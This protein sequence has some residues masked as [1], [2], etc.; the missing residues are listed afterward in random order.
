[1]TDRTRLAAA[2]WADRT[3]TRLGTR[4]AARFE[5][6][7]ADA[8]H[9]D[10][11]DDAR[12]GLEMAAALADH[13]DLLA[14]RHEAVARTSTRWA[15]PRRGWWAVAAAAAAIAVATPFALQTHA[16][17]APSAPATASTNFSPVYRTAIGQRLA[18]TLE[19]GSR[20]TLDTDSQVRVAYTDRERRLMLDRGQAIF[21]VAKHLPRPF[22]VQA[23][24][25]TVTAHGTAFDIRLAP[26]RVRVVLVEGKVSVASRD[27]RTIAME[28]NDVLT[29]QAGAVTLHKVRDVAALTRWRDGALV[30]E[31]RPLA[32]AVTE[33]NRYSIRQLRITDD[34]AGRLRISGAFRTDDATPFIEALRLGFPIRINDLPN[35]DIA[36]ASITTKK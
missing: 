29:A 25:Q 1:V 19:D 34:A 26:D 20:V 32:E 36:I 17:Q 33:L 7:L 18:L 12:D 35:G 6:W 16:P 9:A 23:G 2:S 4:D 8:D 14:L 21:E 30:F 13:A 22:I 31:D 28:P 27:S 10:A 5:T 24:D 3:R 11:Y 15:G